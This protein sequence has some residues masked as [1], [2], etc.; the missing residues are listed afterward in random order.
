MNEFIV[1]TVSLIASWALIALLCVMVTWLKSEVNALNAKSET[2]DEEIEQLA[3]DIEWLKE[4]KK[5]GKLY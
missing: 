4:M 3:S 1:F 2:T 5:A